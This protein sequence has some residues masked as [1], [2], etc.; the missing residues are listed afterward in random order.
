MYAGFS[1]VIMMKH[2]WKQLRDGYFAEKK[3][4]YAY[5]PSGSA[6][7][8]KRKKKKNDFQYFEM[9]GFLNVSENVRY[10]YL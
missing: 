5:K 9:M 10:Y 2:R 7:P 6:A 3:E 8:N 1:T 4:R